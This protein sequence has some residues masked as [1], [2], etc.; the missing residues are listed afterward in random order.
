MY[1]YVSVGNVMLVL[2]LSQPKGGVI[3][4]DVLAIYE[5]LLSTCPMVSP[6]LLDK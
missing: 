3:N 2:Q 5:C 1:V 4:R 6:S